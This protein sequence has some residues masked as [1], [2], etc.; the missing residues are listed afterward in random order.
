MK[1]P[2]THH[3][4]PPG[5]PCASP[6]ATIPEPQDLLTEGN[7][8][9]QAVPA[10]CLSEAERERLDHLIELN[11]PGGP[12][13]AQFG[14]EPAFKIQPAS[15]QPDSIAYYRQDP[16]PPPFPLNLIP[17]NSLNEFIRNGRFQHPPALPAWG[18]PLSQP[19]AP[20]LASPGIYRRQSA[21]GL[22]PAGFQSYAYLS[23]VGGMSH[24]APTHRFRPKAVQVAQA[25][26]SWTVVA[27]RPVGRLACPTEVLV[28]PPYEETRSLSSRF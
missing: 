22:R 17:A 18:A 12:A 23:P 25:P 26:A 24:C 11:H 3:S 5:W 8:V 28:Y 27:S 20:R 14:A 9:G 21:L 19:L 6:R 2:P 16:G 13:E 10:P 7:A 4:Y 1:P 15:P